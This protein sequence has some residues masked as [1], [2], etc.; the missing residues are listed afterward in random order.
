M[1]LKVSFVRPGQPALPDDLRLTVD[2]SATVGELAMSIA[3][4]C[5]R[6]ISTKEPLSLR[7]GAE[8]TGRVIGWST[9]VGDAGLASGQSIALVAVGGRFGDEREHIEQVATLLVLEGPE[10]GQKF[11]LVRGANHIGRE[12]GNDV[13]LTDPLVSKQHAR[14]NVTDVVE[15]VDLGSSNG[16]LIGNEPIPR[17]FLGPEDTVVLGTTALRVEQRVNVGPPAAAGVVFH[18]RAPRLDVVFDGPEID[19]PKPPAPPQRQRLPLIPLIAPVLMGCVLFLVTQQLVTVLFVALSPI[20]MLGNVVENRVFGKRDYAE[21]V[22]IF[23][24]QVAAMVEDLERTVA[25][26]ADTRRREHPS[27]MEAVT[28]SHKRSPLLWALR[29]DRPGFLVLRFGLGRLPA[30]TRVKLPAQGEGAFDLRRELV[31]VAEPFAS[32]DKV[33]VVAALRDCGSVGVAGRRH[34]A[35]GATRA[36]V[37]Q[38]VALHSPADVLLCAMAP[39]EAADTWDW[40][41]WLPHT[42]SDMGP[43]GT[44]HLASTPGGCLHLMTALEELIGRRRAAGTGESVAHEPAIVVLVDEGAAI[45]RA[46][47]VDL[48]ELGPSVAVHVIWVAPSTAALPGACRSFVTVTPNRAELGTVGYVERGVV[49]ADAALDRLGAD[50]ALRFARDLAPVV[51]AGDRLD[52]D[53]DLPGS[54]ALLSLVGTDTASDPASVVDRWRTSGSLA[55]P[56]DERGTR[57]KVESHLRATVGAGKGQSFVLDLRAQGPHALV[58]GTTGSGKS[59]FLQTWVMG[60]ALEHSPNRVTFLFVDYKGGSAFSEC[61]QLPHCVGLVTDLS[62]HLVKRA[63]TSLHAELRHREG[64][65]NAKKAKD[66]L[67]LEKR[68]DPDTPPSLIIVVDEFAALVSEVPEF[69]DGMVNVA[70]RGRSLGLHL[71]L[72][73]QRPAGVI[74]DNL[75]AN[76]NLRIALRM[77]DPDDAVDVAGTP[78]PADFDPALPGRAMARVGPGRTTPFQSAYVGGW[79]SDERRPPAIEIEAMA[80]GTIT[81]WE[82]PDVDAQVAPGPSGPTDLQRLVA[83]VRKAHTQ[84]GLP[85]PRRPWLD[86]LAP[87]YD[88]ARSP[89]SRTDSELI[90]GIIDDPE[91][92]RQGPVAFRP[93]RDGNMVV[94]GTGGAGKSTFLRTLGI[95]AGLSTRGGPCHVYGL[96]FGARGLQM[97]EPLPHVGAIINGEDEERVIRLLRAL[98]SMIDDRSSR[99]AAANAASIDEYRGATGETDEPRVLLLVDGIGAF[100]SAYEVGERGRWFDVFQ[101][102]ASDGRQVGIHVVVSADRGA[103]VPTALGAVIQR[104]LVLRLAGEMEYS[105]LSVDAGGFG[106]ASPAGR[107]FVDGNEVQVTV[108]GGTSDTARQAAAIVQLAASLT[109]AAAWPPAPPVLRLPERVLLGDL[110]VEVDGRPALGIADESLEPIGFLP[111]GVL[112]I[113]GPPRSGRTSVLAAVVLSVRRRQP[114]APLAYLGSTRS[115]LRGMLPWTYSADDSDKVGEVV[116]ALTARLEAGDAA[117]AGLTVVIE[118]LADFLNTAAD[119]PIQELLKACRRHG[120]FVVAEGD[121]ASLMSAWSLVQPF[122]ADKHGIA[123]QPDQLDGDTLFGTPF[124]RVRRA[125]FPAGRGLYVRSG[126]VERVQCALP[127][128]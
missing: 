88:L 54:V 121:T 124:P 107:G 28:E 26:E 44:E 102:I 125:E 22:K 32:V 75:R 33:P 122:K 110:P 65:L 31:D 92:Q 99:Y 61:V 70:Q 49:V 10:A 74:K 108:L 87:A 30:R 18:N 69:V 100:R 126:T 6:P 81:R 77:A 86:S 117:L 76:T 43:L 46:R 13:R 119:Y 11:G 29:S 57:R 40:L 38:L 72:A 20:M 85:T 37:A 3:A 5:P 56:P 25:I 83:T 58:G 89:Q 42:S 45:E 55:L 2:P 103:A 73:T 91:R 101:G 67:E 95:V 78:V 127:E 34:D 39:S 105:M 93:D 106:D 79:T 114:Q 68:G 111:E 128:V 115:P 116:T 1:R 15:I 51:D 59:E 104:R 109:T 90:Y 113:A 8:G 21:A 64:I 47:L 17:A 41:K 66:L 82:A 9:P 50:D 84:L 24:S 94:F 120:G 97:L 35:L 123:L 19:A 48:T 36:L 4:R 7:V 112:L 52:D 96:D 118:G 23:R 16:V 53:S 62:P 27:T 80:F 14:I 98:R 60:L 63:L 71:V 12:A